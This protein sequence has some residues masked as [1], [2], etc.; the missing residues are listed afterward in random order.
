MNSIYAERSL[1][2]M[3]RFE[4][5]PYTIADDWTAAPHPLCALPQ[6]EQTALGLTANWCYRGHGHTVSGFR[7]QAMYLH[8]RLI[9][10]SLCW[11]VTHMLDASPGCK[12]HAQPY[13]Y[14]SDPP[15]HEI[16]ACPGCFR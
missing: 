5:A 6:F 15:Q 2:Y 9:R 1:S 8:L 3:E 12:L 14:R 7:I 16:N 4:N 10:D 11:D 13:V